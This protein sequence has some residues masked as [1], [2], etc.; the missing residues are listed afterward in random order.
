M[1]NADCAKPQNTLIIK[2]TLNKNEWCTLKCQKT[3]VQYLQIHVF[4]FGFEFRQSFLPTNTPNYS[5]HLIIE[6]VNNGRVF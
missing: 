6:C 4:P 3:V 1:V 5:F 2:L